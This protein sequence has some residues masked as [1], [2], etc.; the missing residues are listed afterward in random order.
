MGVSRVSRRGVDILQA[1]R[2]F[3]S[4]YGISKKKRSYRNFWKFQEFL[5]ISGA[6]TEFK[7]FLGIL[8][9]FRCQEIEYQPLVSGP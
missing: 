4:K 1:A 3:R 6:K 5:G 9:I 8:G 7:E 2:N